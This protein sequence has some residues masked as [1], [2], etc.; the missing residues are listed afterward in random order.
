V[1]VGRFRIEKILHDGCGGGRGI[2]QQEMSAED[3]GDG[4]GPLPFILVEASW[5]RDKSS[6]VDDDDDASEN[7][8]LVLLALLVQEQQQ[9]LEQRISQTSNRVLRYDESGSE[10]EKA[11]LQTND[12]TLGTLGTPPPT[13]STP[14]RQEDMVGLEAVV[15]LVQSLWLQTGLGSDFVLQEQDSK[16]EIF[17]FA[18]A[19]A[20]GAAQ[21][22]SAKEMA[23]V[24]QMESTRE[25]LETI[26][27]WR[28]NGGVFWK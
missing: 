8:R 3:N 13:T 19:S 4:G 16:S 7:K 10:N 6:S 22:R 26:V 21:Q 25:R 12:D 15:G 17:S 1:G 14:L 11:N 28:K 23:D 5:I 18:A 20:L 2:T 9:M 24:L 27:L